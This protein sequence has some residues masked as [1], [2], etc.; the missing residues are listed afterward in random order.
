MTTT[1][2][3]L[4]IRALF[5]AIGA[6]L[7]VGVMNIDCGVNFDQLKAE[8]ARVQEQAKRAQE[9][10]DKAIADQKA[11]ADK[12][13]EARDKALADQKALADKAAALEKE[14]RAN[15]IVKNLSSPSLDEEIALGKEISGNLLGAAP[16]VKDLVL[17]RYVN[18]V[19]RWIANH[20]SRPDLPWQFGVIESKDLNAFAAPGGYIFL[21]KGLYQRLRDESQLAGVL[22]HEIGHVIKKHHL[23]LLQKSELLNQGANVTQ[24]LTG[25]QSI[26]SLIGHGAEILARGLDK[27]AELEADRIGLALAARSGYEPYGLP[28]VLYT[29]GE[30]NP[31]DEGLTLLYATHPA[32]ADRLAAL[33]VASARLLDSVNEGKTLA[34]SFYQLK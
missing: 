27:D 6:A 17:Q 4:K 8:A 26:K 10:R 29:L 21:T 19:G 5:I 32:P 33:T 34:S 1:A 18:Q 23:A 16:L 3:T 2:H 28:Q 24:Q 30:I 22:G 13:Q 25:N 11:L 9:A 14:A 20:S 15:P 7:S 12:A 31:S